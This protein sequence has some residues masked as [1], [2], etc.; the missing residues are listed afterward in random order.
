VGGS[1][2]E[3]EIAEHQ[4]LEHAH[5]AFVVRDV[6]MG[7]LPKALN[8]RFEFVSDVVDIRFN[9]CG[10]IPQPGIICACVLDHVRREE[11]DGAHR[12]ALAHE[13]TPLLRELAQAKAGNSR[14][15]QHE[16]SHGQE[17]PRSG[18]AFLY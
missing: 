11:G 12:L 1:R 7:V 4:I 15:D 2:K 10:F 5:N 6:A 13:G 16:G 3:D 8:E 18:A 17:A 9:A 14:H